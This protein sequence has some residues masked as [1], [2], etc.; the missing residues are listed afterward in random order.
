MTPTPVFVLSVSRSGSTLLQRVLASYPQVATASEPWLLLPALSALRPDLPGAPAWQRNQSRAIADFSGG[1]AGGLDAYR[2]EV[3]AFAL[4]LYEQA[5]P[6]DTRLFVDKTPTYFAIAEELFATFP[7]GRFIFLWRN[8]LAVIASL[9]DTWHDGRFELHDHRRDLFDGLPTLIRA[10]QRHRGRA[11][12]VRFEDLVRPDE[13]TW[14][15]LTEE[16][17]LEFDPQSLTGF[18]TVQLNGRMGDQ[19]GSHRYASLSHEPLERWGDTLAGPLRQLWCSRYLAWLGDERLAAMGYDGGEL[20]SALGA[21]PL[22]RQ[23][24]ALDARTLGASLL[25]ELVSARS[26]GGRVSS[27]R[28]LLGA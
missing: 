12:S 19:T 8:P 14:R 26:R 11:V 28:E 13:R 27:W 22:S 1:L 15:R 23:A 9:V 21:L 16:L 17:G 18:A 2:R 20:R 7:E 5:A 24:L 10:Q 4:R 25:R 3:R 6:A